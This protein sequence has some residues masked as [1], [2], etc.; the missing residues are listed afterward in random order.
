MKRILKLQNINTLKDIAEQIKKSNLNFLFCYFK[1]KLEY[2]QYLSKIRF[3]NNKMYEYIGGECTEI[4]YQKAG[5]YLT[6]Y[7]LEKF[8]NFVH[9]QYATSINSK[10]LEK[11]IEPIKVLKFSKNCDYKKTLK[12]LY[13]KAHLCSST[14]YLLHRLYDNSVLYYEQGEQTLIE[15]GKCMGN[16]FRASSDATSFSIDNPPS[17]KNKILYITKKKKYPY[18]NKEFYDL[19]KF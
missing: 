10:Y 8:L 5:Y 12:R 4:G 19:I 6:K 17:F 16:I 2:R 11:L 1:V 18:L 15:K 7:D 3:V 14:H 9:I 13:G